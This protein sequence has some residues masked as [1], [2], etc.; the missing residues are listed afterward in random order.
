MRLRQTKCARA[1]L[2]LEIRRQQP[3]LLLGSAL[4]SEDVGGEVAHGH[5]HR[6]G[7]AGLRHRVDREDVR[8]VVGAG[9]A[10][11]DRNFDAKQ[12]EGRELL[13]QLDGEVAVAVAGGSAGGDAFAGEGACCLG[14]Q[15]LLFC[16]MHSGQHPRGMRNSA[17]PFK[18]C[19]IGVDE[20]WS[21]D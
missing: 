7:R 13:Q 3:R 20:V 15:A 10:V 12:A 9:A 19:L 21:D 8:D 16:E 1:E 11:V 2:A 18:W 5:R 17:R 6:G 4:R 14:D